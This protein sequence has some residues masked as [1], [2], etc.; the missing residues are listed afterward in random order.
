[1][2]ICI[3]SSGLIPS[4]LT[5][6]IKSAKSTGSSAS[7][8]K[9][10]GIEQNAIPVIVEKLKKEI[11][12][13]FAN[14]R[15]HEG[16]EKLKDALCLAKEA[17][18]PPNMIAALFPTKNKEELSYEYDSAILE[19]LRLVEFNSLSQFESFYPALTQL[20]NTP[21]VGL[22]EKYLIDKKITQILALPWTTDEQKEHAWNCVNDLLKVRDKQITDGT[23]DHILNLV[24]SRFSETKF[25]DNKYYKN[26]QSIEINRKESLRRYRKKQAK[27]QESRHYHGPDNFS[28][29][30]MDM[31]LETTREYRA[32]YNNK[33]AKDHKGLPISNIYRLNGLTKIALLCAI[34][35]LNENAQGC[36]YDANKIAGKESYQKSYKDPL[37]ESNILV[38]EILGNYSLARKA[39]QQ[40]LK[41]NPKLLNGINLYLSG[42]EKLSKNEASPAVADLEHCLTKLDK[43][44]LFERM[45]LFDSYC[46][47]SK[48]NIELKNFEAARNYAREALGLSVIKR[49]NK[50]SHREFLNSNLPDSLLALTE[51]QKGNKIRARF[52]I[53]R[54]APPC[55]AYG[56][57]N[58][59]VYHN[60]A[61]AENILGNKIRAFRYEQYAKDAANN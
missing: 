61:L 58:A 8:S 19:S 44:V 59:A 33:E 3:I 2:P 55:R 30:N 60:F 16:I 23:F 32:F 22:F 6:E 34:R 45:V 42:K 29:Q 12:E 24:L 49:L 1:M 50:T 4:G 37:L 18:L 56:P 21:T 14:E 11:K 10:T 28:L 52:H 38:N 53:E 41:D 5:L 47:L 51:A 25:K 35:G 57:R 48:A 13:L 31:C 26:W 7:S 39:T 43:N 9:E 36:L 46:A 20:S 40:F 17:N 54:G 27:Y 15:G